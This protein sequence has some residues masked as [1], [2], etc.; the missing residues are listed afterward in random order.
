[1]WTA[2]LHAIKARAP[3]QKKSCAKYS[4][5]KLLFGL[6]P[7]GAIP[8]GRPATLNK[9]TATL[10]QDS[11]G[12]GRRKRTGG[13]VRLG[14]DKLLQRNGPLAFEVKLQAMLI[15]LTAAQRHLTLYRPI[16]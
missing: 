8:V 13:L 16:P 10:R 15:E 4:G 14:R 6:H 11:G 1:M 3:S 9:L 7:I 12:G 5:N 2:P